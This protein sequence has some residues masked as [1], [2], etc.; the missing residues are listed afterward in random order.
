MIEKNKNYFKTWIPK[1]KEE[2]SNEIN[3]DLID[4]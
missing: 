2:E 4:K 3:S 1:L